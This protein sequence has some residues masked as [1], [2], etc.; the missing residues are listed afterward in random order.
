MSTIPGTPVTVENYLSQPLAIGEPDVS[1]PMAV[2]PVFGAPP[3]LSYI[4]MARAHGQ[5]FTVKEL[6]GGA[7]VRDLIVSNPGP[8]PVLL[9][10]GEEV[11]GA[12][13]NRTFD[14]S[15]L[16][17]AGAEQRV[18]VSCVE[19]GRWDGSRHSEEFRPASHS[20]HPDLRREKASQAARAR[21]AG[22][23]ARADQGLVWDHVAS[24]SMAMGVNSATGSMHDVYENRRNE[25]DELA[26]AIEL[27]DGQIG[28]LVQIGGEV[29]ALDLVSRPDVMADL[30]KPLVTGYSLDAISIA[31]GSEAAADPDLAKGFLDRTTQ[32]RILERDGVGLGRD[33]RFEDA[34]LVG[35]GLVAG[36]ELIQISAFP[37]DRNEEP[38]RNSAA[39]PVAARQ[40]RIV[41]ASRRRR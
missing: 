39:D 11:L 18:P 36:E 19:A 41:R 14:S 32:T 31:K 35:S 2:Y 34:A 13:Q 1:G 38:R 8:E 22:M 4:S 5:G 23:E 9:F 10:E 12:Q 6:P 21:E 28:M 24:K 25:L 3:S 33:F 26:G 30:H 20:S 27:H 7:S 15:I 29:F 40:A 16:V 17:P 37:A